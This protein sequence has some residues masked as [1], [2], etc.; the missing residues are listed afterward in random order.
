[1][2]LRLQTILKKQIYYVPDEEEYEN[3]IGLNVKM[4]EMPGAVCHTETEVLQALMETQDEKKEELKRFRD[5][6]FVNLDGNSAK[7]IAEFIKNT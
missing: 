7:R 5:H 1:M 4:K 6:Y 3:T 2:R